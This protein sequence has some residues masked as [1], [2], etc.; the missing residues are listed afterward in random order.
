MSSN[1]GG[2][3]PRLE[4]LSDWVKD[5]IKETQEINQEAAVAATETRDEAIKFAMDTRPPRLPIGT[6][7]DKKLKDRVR[8]R[9]KD[10]TGAAGDNAKIKVGTILDKAKEYAKRNRE[11]DPDILARIMRDIKPGMNEQQIEDVIT[12]YYP[13]PYLANDVFDFVIE[14]CTGKLQETAREAKGKHEEQHAREIQIGQ[15]ITEQARAFEDKGL[16]SPSK[17]REWYHATITSTPGQVKTSELFLKMHDR[18]GFDKLVKATQFYLAALG[19]DLRKGGLSMAELG[20]KVHQVRSFQAIINVF[21]MSRMRMRVIDKSLEYYAKLGA[22]EQLPQG[23]DFQAMG[24]T[25]MN[26]LQ[27]RHLNKDMIVQQVRAQGFANSEIA[28]MCVIQQ[29]SLMLRDLDS[30]RIFSSDVHKQ[31]VEKAFKECL[32]EL[33]ANAQP[34]ETSEWINS[35][36]LPDGLEDEMS[37]DMA[38]LN[39]DMQAMKEDPDFK[40]FVNMFE[41]G[42]VDVSQ[43]GQF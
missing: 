16:D 41:G 32:E 14:C 2:S 11:L 7:A 36:V 37:Q 23:F 34:E 17:L 20:D 39:S 15:N 28:M 40:D 42:D 43:M 29:M 8:I 6:P 33:Y 24:R 27:N 13:D 5:E 4:S 3:S 12:G 10:E 35:D 31:D 9:R 38:H 25:L 21:R 30:N 18:F 1:I 26:V 19:S 22:R